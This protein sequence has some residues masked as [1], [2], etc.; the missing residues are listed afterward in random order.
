M[1]NKKR[2]I[3]EG[4]SPLVMLLVILLAGV[5]MVLWVVNPSSPKHKPNGSSWTRSKTINSKKKKQSVE[6][7]KQTRDQYKT[8]K[9]WILNSWRPW[10][11]L[12]L[13]TTWWLLLQ[14]SKAHSLKR[15]QGWVE[16]M[17]KAM[18]IWKCRSALKRRW[19]NSQR[20]LTRGV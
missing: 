7:I 8:T 3:E 19:V 1:E 4:S 20:R 12:A 10:M 13:D 17:S 16:A 11:S 5:S 14:A 15:R 6:N 2:D 9:K 18:V